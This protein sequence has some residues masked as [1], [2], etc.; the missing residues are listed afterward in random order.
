VRGTHPVAPI[1]QEDEAAFVSGR[2]PRGGKVGHVD[3]GVLD[4]PLLRFA[5]NSED[6]INTQPFKALQRRLTSWSKSQSWAWR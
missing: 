4:G 1:G 6:A 3:H 2:G 5:E